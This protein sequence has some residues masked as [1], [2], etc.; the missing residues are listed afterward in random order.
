[1][2]TH[3]VKRTPANYVAMSW[4]SGLGTTTELSVFPEGTQLQDGSA[5]WRISMAQVTESGPF[6]VLPQY[7]RFITLVEG[8]GFRI[9]GDRGTW[10]FIRKGVVERFSGAEGIQCT[11]HDPPSTD[12]NVFLRTDRVVGILFLKSTETE[13]EC[14]EYIQGEEETVIAICLEGGAAVSNSGVTTELNRLD[15]VMLLPTGKMG[16]FDLH[17]RQAKTR[18][19]V[20]RIAP[21]RAQK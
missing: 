6:S 15:S 19:A 16:F 20:V 17:L 11:V 9:E 7:E 5:H 1:M 3:A 13:R 12:L 2:P 8:Q 4:P 18:V 14:V 10:S 21:P